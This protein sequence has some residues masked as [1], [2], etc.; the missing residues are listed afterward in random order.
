M[1]VQGRG[2]RV[3]GDAEPVAIERGCGS[4]GRRRGGTCRRRHRDTPPRGTPPPAARTLQRAH[5]TLTLR[6][7]LG[8]HH[9][10]GL[11]RDSS[12]SYCCVALYLH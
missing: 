6:L 10:G 3:K 1:R 8:S 5:N 12:P 7:K 2:W 9:C 4:S 11:R